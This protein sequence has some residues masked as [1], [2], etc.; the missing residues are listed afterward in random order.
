MLPSAG[1]FK[2]I[3]CPFFEDNH[4]C[5]R[6]FCHYKHIKKEKST[7]DKNKTKNTASSNG[8]SYRPT[9]LSLLGQ[10]KDVEPPAYNPTPIKA[11]KIKEEPNRF[12]N[13]DDIDKLWQE[14]QAPSSAD[15]KKDSGEKQ[16]KSRS[17]Q[18]ESRSSKKSRSSKDHQHKSTKDR[19]E[20]QHKSDSEK[21]HHKSNHRSS[22]SSDTSNKKDSK[23]SEKHKKDAKHSK[24]HHSKSRSKD[25]KSSKDRRRSSDEGSG[26][27]KSHDD[28]H[29]K[30]KKSSATEDT[31]ATKKPKSE[32]EED[33][34]DVTNSVLS[35][36]DAMD[37]IDKKL[38][39]TPKNSSQE[40]TADLFGDSSGDEKK[41]AAV[42]KKSPK[43][44]EASPSFLAALSKPDKILK[45]NLE[46]DP[47]KSR[48][49]VS[50]VKSSDAGM[51]SAMIA[52]KKQSNNPVQ[53]MLNRLNKVRV[54]SQTKDLEEQLSALTGQELEPSTSSKAKMEPLEG[55][56][57]GKVQRKAHLMK[58]A[59]VLRRPAIDS[60]SQGK[61]PANVRQK[62]LDT[63]TDECLKMYPNNTAAAYKR[64]VYEEN[65]CSDKSKT[66]SIYLN[67]VV[68]LIKKLRNE[69]KT[70]NPASNSD[71]VKKSTYTDGV[72][73]SII[74]PN[75]L[76]THLQTLIGK[77]GTIGSWS[78]EENKY[79]KF[80]NTDMSSEM[81]YR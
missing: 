64:S 20:E 21:K 42:I 50:S 45:K 28:H 71:S 22:S 79:Q 33:H 9:P 54:E 5:P 72:R 56:R 48:I 18:E 53:A 32:K 14:I 11:T 1:Y 49:R 81:L 3:L 7:V 39:K 4:E 80:L 65:I 57:K 17:S 63:I 76:T 60:D 36:L 52:R 67:L 35:F 66:R 74:T 78:I 25:D 27:R 47:R 75:M 59:E 8:F 51:S 10:D 13:N 61:V 37:A 40:S 31:T 19:K 29:H 58:N 15:D 43:I 62:Y 26:S 6:T 38:E 70:N 34:K 12:D 16:S 69:A 30:R 77:A 46:I 23:T 55:L 44:Q 2:T 68:N 41:P 24:E 73:R